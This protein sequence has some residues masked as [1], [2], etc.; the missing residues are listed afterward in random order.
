MSQ[1]RVQILITPLGGEGNP[2]EVFTIDYKAEAAQSEDSV[3]ADSLSAT[4]RKNNTMLNLTLSIQCQPD[5]HGPM[6]DC[7]DR[8]D[9]SGHFTCTRNGDIE[10]LEGYQNPSTNCTEC[11]ECRELFHML[12]AAAHILLVHALYELHH[13]TWWFL[14]PV[15]RLL[16]FLIVTHLRAPPVPIPEFLWVCGPGHTLSMYTHND[17]LQFSSP[18]SVL[19]VQSMALELW[20]LFEYY[21]FSPHSVSST[22]VMP[23]SAVLSMTQSSSVFVV[24]SGLSSPLS[25]VTSSSPIMMMSSSIQ[26]SVMMSSTELPM[27][28]SVTVDSSRM[29]FS[30]S[31]DRFSVSP[32]MASLQSVVSTSFSS[33]VRIPS[34]SLVQ[35][36]Q[37]PPP[38]TPALIVESTI[39][40]SSSLRGFSSSSSPSLTPLPTVFTTTLAIQQPSS[41]PLVTS[42]VTR[43]PE[44]TVIQ[45]T[46]SLP[47]EPQSTTIQQPPTTTMQGSLTLSITTV[48]EPQTSSSITP[49]QSTVSETLPSSNTNPQ[50]LTTPVIIIPT[51]PTAPPSPTNPAPGQGNAAVIAGAVGVIAAVV[52]L[53]VLAIP[54]VYFIMRRKR[55][56]EKKRA[57]I[58]LSSECFMTCLNA[59]LH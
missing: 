25:T 26:L 44:T 33:V 11:S 37:G 20:L 40:L 2:V 4:G 8:N 5:F 30:P 1:G 32:T 23:S 18:P 19:G 55:R 9:S 7:Q 42:T 57:G 29:Q 15:H 41:S 10:C 28:P 3:T 16:P 27:E 12:H 59:M 50:L 38:T 52:V 54:C 36:T 39:V 31:A 6:C 47:P 56:N 53:I 14:L 13:G 34:I 22:G 51:S 48:Q 58:Y 35:S 17:D 49:E 45:P 46:T 21:Y 43:E 24:Q